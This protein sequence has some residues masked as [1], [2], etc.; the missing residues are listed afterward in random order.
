V[1]LPLPQHID[2]FVVS[3]LGEEQKPG[4]WP[5]VPCYL[6]GEISNPLMGWGLGQDVVLLPSLTG[7]A[8]EIEVPACAGTLGHKSR[9]LGRS[10]RGAV[11]RQRNSSKG[12]ESSGGRQRSEAGRGVG[13]RY[14]RADCLRVEQKAAEFYSRPEFGGWYELGARCKSW[15]EGSQL[16][17]LCV[18]LLWEQIRAPGVGAVWAHTSQRLPLDFGTPH[19]YT[20]REDILN[21]RLEQLGAATASEL[22]QIVCTAYAEH[23]GKMCE[24]MDWSASRPRILQAL[25][26]CLG[27]KGVVALLG[28]FVRVGSFSDLPDLTLVRAFRKVRTPTA[29]G[30]LGDVG[31]A[32]QAAGDGTGGPTA[33]PARWEPLD[34]PKW[35]RGVSRPDAPPVRFNIGWTMRHRED[36]KE[37]R[38]L[39]ETV[40]SPE[41]PVPATLEAE[42]TNRYDSHALKVI[43]GGQQV[44]Y[45]P[46][47]QNQ[48]VTPGEAWLVDT[49]D[50]AR[51]EEGIFSWVLEATPWMLDVGGSRAER[52]GGSEE[53]SGSAT[54]ETPRAGRQNRVP[55]A[56]PRGRCPAGGNA[57]V[58]SSCAEPSLGGEGTGSARGGAHDELSSIVRWWKSKGPATRLLVGW[59]SFCGCKICKRRKS[60]LGCA[61]LRSPA[62]WSSRRER[63]AHT[64]ERSRHRAPRPRQMR[65]QLGI[66]WSFR[67]E[68]RPARVLRGRASGPC[69]LCRRA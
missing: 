52:G 46:M 10:G 21:D 40:A 66:L 30:A 14:E 16:R 2:R 54:G 18:L 37:E 42:P 48:L 28:W 62:Q 4:D 15:D 61:T 64:P 19:L 23:H 53:R 33:A 35:L 27:G 24:L 25:A 55:G 13:G 29:C 32:E 17:M 68:R 1:T 63:A 31:G 5:G 51:E 50:K 12:G 7:D 22:V 34:M 65:G 69:G 67:S 9:T 26:V 38:V 3:R 6:P 57:D 56:G 36:A 60:T 47:T 59:G 11:G 58:G 41:A 49:G 39:R 45:V 20:A 43:V 44:G 8:M